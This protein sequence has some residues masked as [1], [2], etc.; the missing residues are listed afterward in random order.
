MLVNDPLFE[1]IN[2]SLLDQET[3]VWEKIWKNIDARIG[4]TKNEEVKR[5]FEKY[6]RPDRNL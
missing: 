4:T 6:M 5:N 3:V 1:N 2:A